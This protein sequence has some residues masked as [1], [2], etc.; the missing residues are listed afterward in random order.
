MQGGS[1][2]FMKILQQEGPQ[3]RHYRDPGDG[4]ETLARVTAMIPGKESPMLP[5]GC[6]R[7]RCGG[8]R[9]ASPGMVQPAILI[10]SQPTI[11]GYAAPTTRAV[12]EPDSQ[13]LNQRF[14]EDR[15]DRAVVARIVR[16]TEAPATGLCAGIS[17]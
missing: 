4:P 3:Q 10:E 12:T 14:S 5:G 9:S 15:I 2:N 13:Q 11:T 8:L 1:D 6:L 7:D 16:G 17:P